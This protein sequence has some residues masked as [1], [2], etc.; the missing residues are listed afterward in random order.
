MG[1]L[2]ALLRMLNEVRGPTWEIPRRCG[3]LVICRSCGA[4]MVAPLA[5]DEL[6]DTTWWMHLRCGACGYAVEVVVDDEDADAFDRALHRHTATISAALAA[7]E[8]ER[9][10]DELHVL[11]TALELDLID[12]D[13]FTR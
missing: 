11:A 7:S 12:A 13:D 8:R 6:T 9:M 5:W 2:A 4:D 1:R 3:P 10:E